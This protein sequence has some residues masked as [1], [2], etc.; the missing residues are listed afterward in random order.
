MIHLH[1]LQQKG[2]LTDLIDRV[3]NES[4]KRGLLLSAKKTKIMVIDQNWNA[5]NDNF[6]VDGRQLISRFIWVNRLP[7]LGNKYQRRLLARIRRRLGMARKVMMDLDKIWKSKVSVSPK[8]RL[9]ETTIFS[10]ATYVSE[11]RTMQT[12]DRK[13]IEGFEMWCYRRLLGIKW[14]ERRTNFY[15]L[16]RLNYCNKK[17]LA[18]MFKRKLS[19]FGHKLR[20][21]V[22]PRIS[23]W[24]KRRPGRPA[25]V[26]VDDI[27]E[28]LGCTLAAAVQAAQD[29]TGWRHLVSTTFVLLGTTCLNEWMMP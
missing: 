2:D 22:L 23:F 5:E 17:L 29:S 6:Y 21:Y 4:G 3:K 14:S 20:R 11:G 24:G 15:V 13:R 9:V 19:F 26:W 28:L 8:L 7:W 10:V 12:T 1:L 18:S 16:Q 27:T 25:R